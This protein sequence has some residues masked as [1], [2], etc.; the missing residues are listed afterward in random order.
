MDIE[1][2]T[3]RIT[4]MVHKTTGAMLAESLDLPGLMVPGRNIK[5]LED[6]L[7]ASIRE[8]LEAR[9]YHVIGVTAESDSSDSGFVQPTFKATAEVQHAA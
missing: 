4:T 2:R 6:R 7:P 1:K 3:I 9:G 5:E 8:I